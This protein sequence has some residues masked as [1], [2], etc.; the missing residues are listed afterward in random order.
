MCISPRDVFRSL[1]KRKQEEGNFD[2]INII[3]SHRLTLAYGTYQIY[4][5]QHITWQLRVAYHLVT[6]RH[7][8]CHRLETSGYNAPLIPAYIYHHYNTG[9]ARDFHNITN[10]YHNQTY[11]SNQRKTN[12]VPKSEIIK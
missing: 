5:I 10:V 3:I 11:N 6:S 2:E 7:A 12:M 8:V 1:S 4:N 9:A